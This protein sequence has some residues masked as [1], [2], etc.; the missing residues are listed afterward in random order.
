MNIDTS[1]FI[2]RIAFCFI[3]S[4]LIGIE[5]Q[6]RHRMIGLRTNV[7]VGIGAFLFVYLSF[8]VLPDSLDRTRVAS[9]VVCGIGFLGA[10]VILREGSK[11]KG[12]NTAATL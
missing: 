9:Q 4:I 10:G 3:L 2:V 1:V 6:Y 5:R 11:V 8:A 7:L 12:L